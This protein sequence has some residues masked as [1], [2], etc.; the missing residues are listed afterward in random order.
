MD[1]A[2][3]EL[4]IKKEDHFMGKIDELTNTKK[5]HTVQSPQSKIEI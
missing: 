2:K 1:I 4:K 5:P 3:D